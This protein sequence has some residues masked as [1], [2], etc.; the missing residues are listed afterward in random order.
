MIEELAER[1]SEAVAVGL[2]T[3]DRRQVTGDRWQMTHDTQY[4]TCEIRFF[5]LKKVLKS[6]EKGKKECKVSTTTKKAKK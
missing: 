2:V 5:S 4:M 1:G 3:G 6:I